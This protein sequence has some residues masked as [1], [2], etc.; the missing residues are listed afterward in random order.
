MAANVTRRGPRDSR[1]PRNKRERNYRSIVRTSGL[2][3]PGA[4]EIPCA[5]SPAGPPRGRAPSTLAAM[6]ILITGAGGMLGPG[7]GERRSRRRSRAGGARPRRARHHRSR[8]R[9]TRRSRP[10]A[11]MSSSTARPGRTSTAPRPTRTARWRST[12]PA[13]ATWRGRRPRPARGRSTSPATTCSTGQARAVRGIRP[14]RA[15]LGLRPL[16]ARGRARGGRRRAP[17][18]TPS[19]APRGCS[20]PAARAFRRTILR[21]AGERDELTVVDDQVGCPTF[22]GHLAAGAGRAGGVCRIAPRHPARRRRR[23]VLVV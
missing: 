22:T 2:D 4:A 18:G 13:P 8:T 20:G 16:Q 12:A 11:P 10:L 15:R 9:C 3:R 17:D 19:F 1:R 21:L 14:G 5:R 6:R 23:R 7:R